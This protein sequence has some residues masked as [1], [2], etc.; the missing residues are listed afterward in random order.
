MNH[1]SQFEIRE[2]LPERDSYFALFESTGW[3]AEYG[4][5]AEELLKAI[6]NSWYLLCAYDQQKLVGTGRIVSDGV[7]H[8]LIVDVIISPEYQ[9]NGLGTL[10]MQKLV[11]HCRTSGV[12]DVQLF[13]AT[14]NAPF[15]EQLGFTVRSKD[16]PGMDY[17]PA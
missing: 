12:R 11:E 5:H 3:N 16:A 14:G 9:R 10:I 1:I 17:H 6:S 15:Y 13:C 4:L 7:F 8:A 2:C